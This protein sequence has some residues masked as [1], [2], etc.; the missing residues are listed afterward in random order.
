M[1]WIKINLKETGAMKLLHDVKVTKTHKGLETEV[2]FF[3]NQTRQDG[4][5]NVRGISSSSVKHACKRQM[6]RVALLN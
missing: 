5:E 3:F 1:K 4:V 2:L 6:I